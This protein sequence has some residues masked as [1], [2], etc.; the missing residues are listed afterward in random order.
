[1]RQD[2]TVFMSGTLSTIG[3]LVYADN[4]AFEL[5]DP[6]RNRTIKHAY[7]VTVLD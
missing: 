4:L 6:V 5:H 7:D 3:G 2:G 1:M